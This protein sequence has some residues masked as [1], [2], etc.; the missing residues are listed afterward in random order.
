MLASSSPRRRELLAEAGYEFTVVPPPPEIECGVCSELGPAGLVAELAFRKALAVVELLQDEEKS[1]R[2]GRP[3]LLAPIVIAADT[4]AEYDGFILGKP[5]DEEHARA[6]LRQL[7]GREHRVL[8]GLCLWRL[9]DR[10]PLVRVAVTTL[11]MDPL[12]GAQLDEYLASGQW[13]GKAGAFGY[14]DRLGWVHIVEGS[15]SNVVGLPME[16][17]AELLAQF[18]SD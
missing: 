7:S 9:G 2:P 12:S 1:R 11:R 5:H 15:E 8:T 6:M 10:Q 14:Q 16:L 17:L 3:G 4:V 13:E 18:Q